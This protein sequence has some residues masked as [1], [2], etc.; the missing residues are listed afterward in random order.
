MI[1]AASGRTLVL[2]PPQ[3]MY[4]LTAKRKFEEF[5]PIFSESLQKRLEVITSKEFVSREM[6]KGG[7][8][9]TDDEE[10]KAKL[11]EAAEGCDHMKASE[12]HTLCGFVVPDA[13]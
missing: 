6:V 12:F 13:R 11:V 3:T 4:L 9:E 5:F 1:A 2:P 7:Y 8:L 10:L